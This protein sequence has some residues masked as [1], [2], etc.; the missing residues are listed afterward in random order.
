MDGVIALTAISRCRRSPGGVAVGHLR[1]MSVPITPVA[2]GTLE[3]TSSRIVIAAVCQP[4]AARPSKNV[5]R[6]G[7]VDVEALR[8]IARRELR[9]FRLGDLIRVAAKGHP[10]GEVVEPQPIWLDRLGRR[11][12]GRHG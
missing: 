7:P 9:H 11:A 3:V 5:P 12:G 4:L 8:V 1:E 10:F 6:A 2:I